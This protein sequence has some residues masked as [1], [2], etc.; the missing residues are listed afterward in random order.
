[1]LVVVVKYLLYFTKT[2]AKRMVQEPFLSCVKK[3][4]QSQ[5]HA[6]A[7]ASSSFDIFVGCS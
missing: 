3:R 6:G 1:M 2:K 4:G 7:T 5:Q